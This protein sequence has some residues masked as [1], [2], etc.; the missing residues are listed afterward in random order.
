[1]PAKPVLAVVI[2]VYNEAENLTRLLADWLPVFNA[3][4]VSFTV[5][6]ID[7]GSTDE[8]LKLMEEQAATDPILR[9]LTQPN[10]GHGPAVLKGYR[11][12]ADAEW[13]FQIDSDH[14]LKTDT[15]KVIW[16]NRDQFDL[17]MGERR[18][19]NATRG[20]QWVTQMSRLVAEI[21]YG[22][23][24]R[25]V[26]IPYRL[27]RGPLLQKALSAIPENSFAPNVLLTCWFLRKKYRIFVTPV[28]Q[29]AGGGRMSRLDGYFVRGAIRSFIQTILF[30]W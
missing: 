24:V 4:G 15:F 14:Q 27:M 21:L 20:R 3:T 11:L 19:P 9:L 13:V 5:L 16:D 18:H 29:R 28:E 30:R 8:S 2:P 23:G 26:N 1:M 7:D 22:K 17:L 12:A 10:A 25:D 6:L